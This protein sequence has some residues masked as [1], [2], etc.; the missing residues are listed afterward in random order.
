MVS[1]NIIHVNNFKDQD[2][3]EIESLNE[4]LQAIIYNYIANNSEKHSFVLVT[5]VDY[6]KSDWDE[7]NK[8]FLL[9]P[10]YPRLFE[11]GEDSFTG[12]P[13]IIM[14]T[15]NAVV[16]IHSPIDIVKD[17]DFVRSSYEK[18]EIPLPDSINSYKKFLSEAI[19]ISVF[20]NSASIMS[21]QVDTLLLKNNTTFDVPPLGYK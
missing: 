12:Y 14:K 8:L 5:D 11:W 21:N 17:D 4:E 9:G 10:S 18:Q 20:R 13:T 15:E 6:K 3:I 19:A 7:R 2:I 1:C 16:F